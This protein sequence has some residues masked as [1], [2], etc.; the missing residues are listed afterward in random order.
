MSS[1]SLTPGAS[2]RLRLVLEHV[3]PSPLCLQCQGQIIRVE[4]RG[5]KVGVAAAMN[6]YRLIPEEHHPGLR[7][8]SAIPFRMGRTAEGPGSPRS[9]DG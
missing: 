9:A 7:E 8:N 2:I 6:S 4:R 5:G 3:F 1:E